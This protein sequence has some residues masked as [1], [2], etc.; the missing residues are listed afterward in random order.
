MKKD[1][2]FLKRMA[3]GWVFVL[4]TANLVAQDRPPF[5]PKKFDAEMEQFIS[6]EACLTPQ[7]AAAFFPLFNEMQQKQRLLFNKMK[8]Y[9][10]ID[11]NDNRACREAIKEQDEID[12]QIK[13]IQQQ[14]HQKFMKVLSPG[15]VMR[16][17]KAEDRFHRRAFMHAVKQRRNRSR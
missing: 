9:R 13:K 17:I 4:I 15:K 6:Q 16:V 10:H 2:Q 14:Y 1:I 5:D 11:T 7:E 8:L 12:I 3:L